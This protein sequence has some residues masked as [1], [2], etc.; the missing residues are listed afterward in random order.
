MFFVSGFAFCKYDRGLEAA[1]GRNIMNSRGKNAQQTQPKSHL[2]VWDPVWRPRH[3]MQELVI[4]PD[5]LAVNF[6]GGIY[7]HSY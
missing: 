1:Y 6:L 3:S 2:P 5:V 4:R 7:I